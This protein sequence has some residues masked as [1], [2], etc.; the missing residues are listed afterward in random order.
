M[1]VTL[2]Q[3]DR[4]GTGRSALSDGFAIGRA[5]VLKQTILLALTCLVAIAP[6][7]AKNLPGFGVKLSAVAAAYCNSLVF[8]SHGTLYYT[9]ATGGIYRL[10]NGVSTKLA[11][12]DTAFMGNS[13]LLG[14]ALLDDNTAIV[15]YTQSS[16]PGLIEP[17]WE[18]VSKIDLSSGAE[19]LL[20]KLPDDITYPGRAVTF[21]HHGGHPTIGENGTVWFGIG[22]FYAFAISADPAWYAGKIIRIDPDKKLTVVASGFRNPYGMA[23]DR[24]NKR[25][26]V[27]DNG[28]M[29][30]DEI[31]IVTSS[32]GYF[33]WPCTAGKAPPCDSRPDAVRPI[34]TFPEIVAPT[35]FKA[36]NG[37][38]PYMRSGYLTTSY[39]TM[40]IYYFPDIDVRPVPEPIQLLGGEPYPLI[41]VAL[42]PNGDIYF[43]NSMGIYQLTLPQRGDCDADGSVTLRDLDA[44]NRELADGDPHRTVYAQEGSFA[45]SWGCDANG[46]GMISA[47]D[48]GALSELL[49]LRKRP[50]RV[51]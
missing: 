22:D 16:A 46:D 21:E 49:R 39:V 35:G 29:A 38:N 6:L 45:G 10:D 4:S 37:E 8:D 23:W 41:D 17:A 50:V 18:V 3:C 44:L 5:H 15:H 31:N 48:R 51:H 43:T 19:T 30:N 47:A 24:T 20:A 13:G 28:D 25:L 40:T 42:A 2:T 27:A 32:G 36:V 11:Q 1:N 12:V 9:T 7:Q 14:M 34:Y 26:V 33:G